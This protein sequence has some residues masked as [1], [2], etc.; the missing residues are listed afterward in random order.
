MIR[1][2]K[3]TLAA[4]RG[5]PQLRNVYG[6]AW[7]PADP[8]NQV[9]E[10]NVIRVEVEYQDGRVGTF[11]L[12]PRAWYGSSQVMRR[13]WLTYGAGGV[14]VCD[15][16]LE[17]GDIAQ[18]VAVERG[19][20]PSRDLVYLVSANLVVPVVLDFTRP[21]WARAG[22]LHCHPVYNNGNGGA[23][24]QANDTLRALVARDCG[25]AFSGAPGPTTRAI[26]AGV[27]NAVNMASIANV[28]GYGDEPVRL[29]AA[30]GEGIGTAV[31]PAADANCI[32][33][34][35]PPPDRVSVRFWT[36]LA[37]STLGA[38]VPVWMD[39]LP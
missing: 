10:F 21:S 6:F 15:V 9:S 13:V 20:L 17:H 12:R 19:A 26:Y 33:Q 28:I 2:E 22:A 25:P 5:D 29:L 36:G 3:V 38:G 37:N 27:G 23:N 24:I 31:V 30:F 8:D 35:G 34:G 1:S 4:T 32:F 39:W 18:P 7:N 16:G 11:V 14:I